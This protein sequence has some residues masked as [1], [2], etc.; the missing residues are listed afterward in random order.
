MLSIDAPGCAQVDGP[1]KLGAEKSMASADLVLLSTVLLS[2]IDYP[3]VVHETARVLVTHR[4]PR[5][6]FLPGIMA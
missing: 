1:W 4:G 5:R 6:L 3:M 2:S